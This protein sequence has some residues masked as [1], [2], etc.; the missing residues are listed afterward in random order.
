MEYAVNEA[1]VRLHERGVIYRNTRLVNW[2]CTLRS[3]I[4]DIEVDK[5]ELTGRTKLT[6]PG[7]ERVVEFGVITEFSYKLDDGTKITVATT[8]LETMLGDVAIAV[9]PDDERYTSFIGKVST[10]TILFLC[11]LIDSLEMS[12]SIRRS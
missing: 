3:A 1:F 5:R 7:Y 8:R 10:Y 4:S 9:H 2:C 12:A 6:V 11:F